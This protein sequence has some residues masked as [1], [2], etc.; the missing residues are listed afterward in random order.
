MSVDL[1]PCFIDSNVWLYALLPKQDQRK[2]YKAHNLIQQYK[3][4]TVVSTQVVNEVVSNMIK[5]KAMDEEGLR[6]LIHSF[7]RD[8]QVVIADELVQ[9]DAS[10]LRE[11]YSFS[12]WDSLIISAALF[13]DA[14]ILYS[15]DMQDGLLVD[16]RLTIINPF[17]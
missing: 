5:N 12:Y 4:L 3:G 2:E 8:C 14:T 10:Q 7:Y 13:G 17:K 1:A 16:G 9:I 6:D 11:R 15:E